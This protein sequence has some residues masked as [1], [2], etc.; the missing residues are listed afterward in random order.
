MEDVANLDTGLASVPRGNRGQRNDERY[1]RRAVR[2]GENLTGVITD[3]SGIFGRDL[4]AT[5]L[6]EA[7][8]HGTVWTIKQR[9]R[10]A[11]YMVYVRC[12]AFFDTLSGEISDFD[13]MGTIGGHPACIAT[14]RATRDG[15]EEP[16]VSSGGSV[17]A[18]QSLT[19]RQLVNTVEEGTE[20]LRPPT[21]CYPEERQRCDVLRAMRDVW[22]SVTAHSPD[23]GWHGIQRRS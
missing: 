4:N 17:G 11:H 22:E 21:D 7:Q 8:R 1:D 9:K 3:R 2:P 18:W 16:C 10:L 20:R 6:G 5:S 14:T 19:E 15:Q 23:H 12:T 13:P